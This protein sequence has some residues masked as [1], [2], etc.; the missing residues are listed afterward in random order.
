MSEAKA[1]VR[2]RLADTPSEIGRIQGVPPPLVA[3]TFLGDTQIA[4]P[5]VQQPHDSY[6]PP[7]RHHIIGG[8][9]R[10]DGT[11]GLKIGGKQLR[12]PSVTERIIINPK[13]HDGWWN[14]PG[15]PVVS[16]V[17]I[18]EER[19]QRCADEIGRGTKPE[20]LLTLSAEDPRLFKTLSLIAEE[21]ATEDAISR[22][23]LEQLVDVLCLQVL[24][25]HV[26]FPLAKPVHKGG[27]GAWQLRRVTDYMQEHLADD[28]GLETLASLA[29]LSRFHFCRTFRESTGY[30]P[31]Q[32]LVLLRMREARRLLANPV[33]TVTDVALA[34]GY[35]TPSA[36]AL[37]F[38]N[39]IGVTPSAYRRCL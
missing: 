5:W 34:V 11:T 30:T 18:G 36:F 32:W 3:Q 19:L 2:R 4:Y 27:L 9:F 35:K 6:C 20:L 37:A 33:L 10:G 13:G 29:R 14:C 23:C 8:V 22:L 39:A 17:F 21:S 16:N 24:R 12:V 38:R 31:N 26:A 25:S 15:S 1:M 7:M 28:V